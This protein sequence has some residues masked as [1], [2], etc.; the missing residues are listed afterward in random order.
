MRADLGDVL[1]GSAEESAPAQQALEVEVCVV[2]PGVAHAAK[3]LDRGVADGRQLRRERFC[4]HG[5]EVPLRGLCRVGGPERV[6]DAA[7]G[8][9]DR[10]VHVDAEVLD[11]LK[12]ADRLA[13]LPPHLRVLD[14]LVH[15]RLRGAEGVSSVGGEDIVD[16]RLDCFREADAGV[17]PAR[18][19][20]SPGIACVSG[21]TPTSGV[22]AM[23]T[24]DVCTAKS[25]VPSLS[26][27][28]TSNTSAAATSGTHAT[29]PVSAHV[30]TALYSRGPVG[31]PTG[32]Q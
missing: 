26:S 6:E 19:R 11:R 4:P 32:R 29:V 23:P 16:E 20:V 8:E 28:S 15:H 5:R 13:E 12:A 18:P 9:L 31:R 14:G 25:A 7:A 30:W 21:S 1:I 2:L 27:A 24:D 3:N 17:A 10:L 22:T